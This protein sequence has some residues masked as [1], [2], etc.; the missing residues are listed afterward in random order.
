[1]NRFISAVI[2]LWLS[3]LVGVGCY[4]W[5]HHPSKQHAQF[6]VGDSAVSGDV[7]LPLT[8][9]PPAAVKPATPKQWIKT[10]RLWVNADGD[11]WY[12]RLI[13]PEG[14]SQ[15]VYVRLAVYNSEGYRDRFI[16]FLVEPTTPGEK[17]YISGAIPYRP[18]STPK[19]GDK[20]VRLVLYEQ[21]MDVTVAG[22]W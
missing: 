17:V 1:M 18:G 20:P 14:T 6:Q 15:K 4:L 11:I 8:T 21:T 13:S 22:G 2:A 16:S 9:L 19:D 7:S 12:A 3:V 5:I 10:V